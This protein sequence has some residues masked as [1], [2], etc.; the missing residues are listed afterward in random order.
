MGT[1]NSTDGVVRLRISDV[2]SETADCVSLAFDVPSDHQDRFRYAAG[3]YLTLRVTVAGVEHRRCYSMSSS[4]VLAEPLRITVKR[5]PG[6][7]VSNWINDTVVAG[8]EIHAEAP[9]GR[10][11]LDSSGRDIVAFAGGS[12]ITPVFSLIRTALAST[13]R[14][15]RLF[16]A[17][18][19]ADS[20]IFDEPLRRLVED[21]GDRVTVH[22]HLD[23]DRGVVTADVLAGFLGDGD[24][25]Y[26]VCGP[27][28]FMDAVEAT[29][30][31]SAVPSD[32]VHLERFVAVTPDP[33]PAGAEV[34]E[35]VIIELD[36]RT[37]TTQYRAG[38]T[39]LQTA[40][41]AGLKAPSSCETG[42]CGTCIAQL[43]DGAARM[44]N[45]NALTD[46]EVADGLVLTCQALPTTRTVR[47]I[48]E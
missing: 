22:H 6:G 15:V 33:A 44:L 47:V 19:S 13:S 37:T 21:Y 36:R 20:V 38:N 1:T 34:T 28:P 7:V 25:E 5:D 46:D 41:M 24:A 29:L 48:Y 9:Q 42:S 16:Y 14:R 45:N 43:T 8:A 3:Q 39:L 27:T 11:V 12:G 31:Q 23:S 40:R 18:R 35:E 10:F 32:R 30:Q 4:P 26:F 2:Q 17:N